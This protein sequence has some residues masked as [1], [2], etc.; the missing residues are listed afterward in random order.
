MRGSIRVFVG[1]LVVFGAVGGLEQ[2]MNDQV[3][4][5]IGCMV[6]AAGGLFSMYS[7]VDAMKGYNV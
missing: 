2:T 3:G 6:L 1:L 7:G 5:L 4:Q